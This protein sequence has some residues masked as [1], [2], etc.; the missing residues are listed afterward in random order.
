M[1]AVVEYTQSEEPKWQTRLTAKAWKALGDVSSVRRL[2]K[3]RARVTRRSADGRED[4]APIR[5]GAKPIERERNGLIHGQRTAY[6]LPFPIKRADYE[7]LPFPLIPHIP[8]DKTGRAAVGGWGGGGPG[9]KKAKGG[10][11]SVPTTQTDNQQTA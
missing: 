10:R 8:Q 5:E 9:A 4:L 2:K 3:K 11:S 7:S 6:A 1:G